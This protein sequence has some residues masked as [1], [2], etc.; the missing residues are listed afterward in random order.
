[1]GFI[2][3]CERNWSGMNINEREDLLNLLMKQIPEQLKVGLYVFRLA[4]IPSF[5]D[6]PPEICGRLIC[7]V[8]EKGFSVDEHNRIQ[9][10]VNEMM[11][12]T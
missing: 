10:I 6:L 8:T 2:E 9:G 7:A 11:R 3:I 1:M 12:E 4:R 5:N